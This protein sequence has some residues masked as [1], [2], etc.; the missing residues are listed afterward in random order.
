[1]SVNI[2]I[3]RRA[4]GSAGAP[5]SLLNAELA[6]NEVDKVLYY[7]LGTGGANGSATVVIPIGG[8]GAFEDL[9]S[10]QTVGGNK[11]YAL[12]PKAP[13]PT[14]GDNSTKV[15]TTAFVQATVAPPTVASNTVYAGP[16]ASAGQPSYRL[17]VP[18]DVP[19]LMA[20]KIS[21]FS[22]AA[23]ARISL[24]RG[25]ASGVCP[26]D[27]NSLV[28]AAFLPSY[29]D[30]VKEYANVAAFPA[31]GETDKIYLA[32]D[33]GKI[34][35]WSGTQYIEISPSPGSTDAVPEGPTNKYFTEAR[36]LATVAAG[37]SVTTNAV[38][39]ATDS[40]LSALGKL[41]A[42]VTAR[43]IA[44]NNLSDLPSPASAR[45]NLGLGTMAVQNASAVAIT[46]GTVDGIVLDGGLY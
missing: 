15:A 35:R 36:V 8:P 30:D 34:Y 6:F 14:T 25:A 20:A 13:T 40:V 31:N 7:G 45:T 24:A 4:S 44:A 42:Q 5:S 12:S 37:L 46:G 33:S 32:D 29:V 38:I 16:T 21:D 9:S 3:K 39:S 17:L 19:S 2:R 41:Q 27:A 28:P 11:T 43:L 10:D 23:D 1:M 26:L 18:Q 22:A